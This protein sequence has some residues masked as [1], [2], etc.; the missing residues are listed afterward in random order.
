ML[1]SNIVKYQITF[2][3]NI[4]KANTT[5]VELFPKEIKYY[6]FIFNIILIINKWITLI[7]HKKFSEKNIS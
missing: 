4:D 3:S 7:N 6:F 1:I 2:I 5:V